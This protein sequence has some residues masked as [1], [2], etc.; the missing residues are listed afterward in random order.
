MKRRRTYADYS[1]C[2]T[3]IAYKRHLEAG[4]SPC[5]PCSLVKGLSAS[6]NNWNASLGVEVQCGTVIGFWKHFSQKDL[7]PCDRCARAYNDY[8]RDRG[9]QEVTKELL[10]Q[11]RENSLVDEPP[12]LRDEEVFHRV[13]T[14]AV[15]DPAHFIRLRNEIF[16]LVDE[17]PNFRV[18][19]SRD[20]ERWELRVGLGV[21]RASVMTL[22]E[23]ARKLREVC[24]R[25]PVL[26]LCYQDLAHD[27]FREGFQAGRV[28]NP[29]VGST[30]SPGPQVRRTV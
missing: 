20:P 22:I 23:E 4:E 13:N 5:G 30:A 14:S 10:E 7:N 15:F 18:E 12:L 8:Q 19:C 24:L 2:G 26:E 25:C 29:P 21:R 28:I 17:D 6:R 9:Q 1:P 3:L 27:P 16:R 11:V